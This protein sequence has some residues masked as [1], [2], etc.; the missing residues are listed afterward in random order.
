MSTPRSSN[1]V[2]R[3]PSS[4]NTRALA[5][6]HI[7]R[8][9]LVDRPTSKP[10]RDERAVPSLQSEEGTV[11]G[12]ILRQPPT[13][14]ASFAVVD[15]KG[16]PALTRPS[17]LATSASCHEAHRNRSASSRASTAGCRGDSLQLCRPRPQ[18][19]V[20]KIGKT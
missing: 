7:S 13:S 5:R 12:D 4:T 18:A 3:P 1:L 10:N 8:G 9:A 20:A 19:S 17:T 16:E 6:L 14:P 15:S 2:P 11:R